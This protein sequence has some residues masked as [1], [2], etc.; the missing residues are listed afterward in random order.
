LL[1]AQCDHALVLSDVKL[2]LLE[3]LA[4]TTILTVLQRLGL[5]DEA[6]TEVAWADLDRAFEPDHLTCLWVPSLATPVGAELVRFVE[7]VHTLR[8]RCPW[9]RQQTHASLARYAL[10]EA[11]ELIEAIGAGDDDELAEE[12]GDVLLQVVLHARLAEDLP[13]DER[14]SVDDVAGDLVAKL[15]RRNP[16]VFAGAAVAS[17]DEIVENWEQ[18]KR[19]EKSRESAVEG[20][21]LAQPALSLAAKVLTR[22]ERAGLSRP[23][24]AAPDAVDTSDAGALGAALF[25]IVAAARSAG[26]DAEAALRRAVLDYAEVLRAAERG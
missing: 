14:W 7:I 3:R 12:L 6:V 20:I 25:G 26:V 15:I 22:A 21:A 1:V 17:V 11:Y 13:E 24:P 2:T 19:A 10:E 5:P 4:P 18:I 9:D 8:E 16:H 23:T